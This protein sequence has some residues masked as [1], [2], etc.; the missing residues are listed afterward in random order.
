MTEKLEGV[1]QEINPSTGRP[2]APTPRDRPKPIQSKNPPK[3]P[4][5]KSTSAGGTMILVQS[6]DVDLIPMLQAPEGL[7]L[8]AKDPSSE[9]ALEIAEDIINGISDGTLGGVLLPFGWTLTMLPVP[10]KATSVDEDEDQTPREEDLE[11][12]LEEDSEDNVEG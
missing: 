10:K 11:V 5:I 7:D 4:E 8:Y 12:D 2:V 6:Q 3:R 1:V 9:A